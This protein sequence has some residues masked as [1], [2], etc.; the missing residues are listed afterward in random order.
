MTTINNKHKKEIFAFRKKILAETARQDKIFSKICKKLNIGPESEDGD[1][2]F[3]H[4]YNDSDW[5]VVYTDE[6]KN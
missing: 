1:A 3:D 4:I 5:T 6:N 2:L